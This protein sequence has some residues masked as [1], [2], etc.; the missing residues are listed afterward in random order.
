M[1]PDVKPATISRHVYGLYPSLA[2]LAGMQL[3][4]FT[5]LGNGAM[6]AQALAD[7]LKVD[8]QKLRRLLYALVNA[9]L[10][11]VDGDRFANTPEADAYLVRGRAA[12]MGSAH[13]L[14]FDLWHAAF[15]AGPSI[16]AGRPLARSPPESSSRAATNS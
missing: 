6:T 1:P 16:R 15:T 14:Y 8:A 2:M 3:D 7:V 11:T 12:Y 9:E 13:E 5:P 4:V 10:L